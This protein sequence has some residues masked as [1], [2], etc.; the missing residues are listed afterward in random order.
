MAFFVHV[1]EACAED[2]KQHGVLD[3][4]LRIR[5]RVEE[6]G[7]YVGFGRMGAGPF[8]KR[9][10]GNFR[11]VA[12][13]KQ[14]DDDVLLVF[15][16]VFA[17]GKRQYEKFLRT[18]KDKPSEAEQELL[19]L[20]GRSPQ[21][22]YGERRRTK[23][24]STRQAP[25]DD[26]KRWLYPTIGSH[27]GAAD[28]MLLESGHWVEKLRSSRYREKAALYGELLTQLFV[29][30]DGLER[31]ESL[32]DVKVH[33]AKREQIG[34]A[35]VW[36]ENTQEIL[37]IAPLRRGEDPNQ[38]IASH[39]RAVRELGGTLENARQLAAR[40]YPVVMLLDEDS[41][42]EIEKDEDAN[43]ALSPEEAALLNG[44]RTPSSESPAHFPLFI[45]GRAG[46]GK[47]TMLHYLLADYIEYALRNDL[48]QRILYVTA[49][50]DLAERARGVVR[51]LL[52]VHHERLMGPPLPAERVEE[53]VQGSVVVFH[54]FLYSLLPPEERGR[55]PRARFVDFP[56]FRRLWGEEMRAQRRTN[57]TLTPDLAWH[58]VRSYIKG[59]GGY[60]SYLDP[61][62]FAALP[63]RQRSLSVETYKRVWKE[64]W[65]GWYAKLGE[66]GYWDDQD[67]VA[68]VLELDLPRTQDCAAIF[69]DEAQ[70]FTSLDLEVIFQLSLF[71]RRSLT[72]EEFQRVPIVFAGDPLQTINPTGFRWDAVQAD[73]HEKFAAV[74]DSRRWGDKPRISFRELSF[75]YRSNPGIVRFCNLVQLGRAVALDLRELEAQKPW[76]VTDPIQVQL[77][78]LDGDTA[79][80]LRG[81]PDLV[82]IVNCEAGEETDLVRADPWLRDAVTEE[83][84]GVFRNVLSPARAKGLEFPAVVLYRFGDTAPEEFY[85]ALQGDLDP[86]ARLP[87][88]YFFNRLYVAASRAKTQLFIADTREAIQGFWRWATD[89]E[90]FDQLTQRVARSEEQRQQWVKMLGQPVPA[91]REWWTGHQLS[92]TE[93]AVDYERDGESKRDPYLLRQAAIAYRNAGDQRRAE[94]CLAKAAECEGRYSDAG[95]RYQQ[96]DMRADAYRCFWNAQEWRRLC[97]LAERVADLANRVETHAARFMA[98]GKFRPE[99]VEFLVSIG[100]DERAAALTSEDPIWTDVLRESFE[101][102]KGAKEDNAL[103]WAALCGT[104]V[105]LRPHLREI[106]PAGLAE[107]AFRGEDFARAIRLWEEAGHTEHEQYYRAHAATAPFPEN[108]RSLCK[109]KKY[110]EIVQE[111]RLRGRR[112]PPRVRTDPELLQVVLEAATN[113]GEYALAAEILSRS[114]SYNASRELFGKLLHSDNPRLLSRVAALVVR[115][116]VREKNVQRWVQLSKLLLEQEGFVDGLLLDDPNRQWEE[117]IR[118]PS[119]LRVLVRTLVAELARSD[120]VV[121]LTSE[122]EKLASALRDR[123]I[124]AEP[125]RPLLYDMSPFVA[126]AA[127]ERVCKPEDA[128]RY[129]RRLIES[130]RDSG[131]RAFAVQ[132]LVVSLE[133]VAHASLGERETQQAEAARTE[134][135][136]LRIRHQLGR[137]LLPTYPDLSRTRVSRRDRLRW[138]DVG[139]RLPPPPQGERIL[140]PLRIEWSVPKRLVRV[141]H[142][143]RLETVKL[144]LSVGALRGDGDTEFVPIPTEPGQQAWEIPA[145]PA[146]IVVQSR[147]GRQLVRISTAGEH[148][149]VELGS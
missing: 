147:K 30:R 114:P 99:F 102:L 127:I 38:I 12:W 134:A 83:I 120:R 40:A 8:L 145:W 49:S 63:R 65:Q 139:M 11:L 57:G 32:Q 121:R 6:A 108:L 133:R 78:E 3:H 21:D 96:L 56:K 105:T 75:N 71:G 1:T 37:L 104:F 62:E 44:I 16:R 123:V 143:D 60:Q 141:S 48:R 92:P 125:F 136:R 93:Q 18:S 117:K 112:L 90:A 130:S 66:E 76:R 46:S 110:T 109:L 135:R 50:A 86:E 146:R 144:D 69:C 72:P 111:W 138:G 5:Q 81:R 27:A 84:D 70:D 58:T 9:Q 107:F 54:D 113:I 31:S 97:S 142:R 91:D 17:R 34:I 148:T 119:T 129:Y 61:H 116:A 53:V 103:P 29:D 24:P 137:A 98:N 88:E 149:D 23:A 26:E 45:N 85:Q 68:R 80:K 124:D 19:D 74:L 7:N 59:L 79:D 39:R 4:V 43:L 115:S 36:P 118:A 100:V 131:E 122:K 25:S 95:E 42:L 77:V 15:C 132:R 41:W 33:W 2:A 22:I 35:Y 13:S 87:V 94:R 52:G 14:F 126:G 106:D 64:V 89:T 10:V 67:L 20:H 47:S 140:G 82:K 101:R 128:V 28:E 51:R 73:Y 55:F